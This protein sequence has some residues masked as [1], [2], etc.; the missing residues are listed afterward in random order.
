MLT[1]ID[2]NLTQDDIIEAIRLAE[3]DEIINALDDVEQ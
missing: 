3:I 1:Y 2:E